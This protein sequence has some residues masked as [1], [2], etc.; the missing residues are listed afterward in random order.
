MENEQSIDSVLSEFGRAQNKARRFSTAATVV[1]VLASIGMVGLIVAFGMKYT[2]T[3]RTLTGE[4]TQTRSEMENNLGELQLVK[5]ELENKQTEL[6]QLLETIKSGSPSAEVIT[7]LQRD[8]TAN[9]QKLANADQQITELKGLMST[10]QNPD[11]VAVLTKQL[12]TKESSIKVLK[13]H[14]LE[15]DEEITVKG[16]AI[17]IKDKDIAAKSQT[18]AQKDDEISVKVR[19]IL[20]K[21]KIIG[22]KDKWI[23]E[24][25]RTIAFLKR[26]CAEKVNPKDSK[27]PKQPNI[28]RK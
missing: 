5:S 10:M 2:S 9:Q 12:E 14:L 7:G 3:E 1:G 18:I 19:I 21:D 16:Q 6:T 25:E 4:V 13:N 24:L 15:K 8:L 28:Q 11:A 17:E 23:G 22:G 20:D 26:Q 27:D